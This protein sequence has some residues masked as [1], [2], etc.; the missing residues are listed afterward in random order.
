MENIS[1]ILYSKGFFGS[2]LKSPTQ[3]GSLSINNSV[4]NISGL[5]TFKQRT[6]QVGTELLYI[7]FVKHYFEYVAV[8][9]NNL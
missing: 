4:M 1:L 9:R 3:M 8:K 5:G 7:F 2:V 6:P